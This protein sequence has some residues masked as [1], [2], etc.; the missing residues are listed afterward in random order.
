MP[1]LCLH[2]HPGSSQSMGV[3]TTA[4]SESY[5]TI[6]PDLRGYGRSQTRQAFN[7]LA[8]LE[9]LDRVVQQEEEF[10]ILGWSLGGILAMEMALRHPHRVRGLILIAT[11]AKPRGSHP[12][13]TWQDNLLT[14]FAGII[15]CIRPAWHWNIEYLGKRSLF[16]YLIQQHTPFA[17]RR[18]AREGTTAYLQTSRV[19][20]QA[21]YNAIRQGYNR[22]PDLE[23]IQVPCLVLCGEQDRHITA[24]ASI[25]T[26]RCLPTC[27]LRVY[28]DTAHLFP[29]EIP[30][31]VQQDILG[32]ITQ[33][34]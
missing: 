17:Y 27:D 2:G 19:A 29:W 22:L 11:A 10:W 8:H 33:Q 26:A 18:L 15:N 16:R 13:V 1:V 25:E 32:W 28:P 31:Q 20:T 21:L 24:Q 30:A 34:N 12:P 3:F 7:M 23:T 9:D 6:A 5:R 14:G 4:L